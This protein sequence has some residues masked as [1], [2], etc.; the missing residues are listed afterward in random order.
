MVCNQYVPWCGAEAD[1]N[2]EDWRRNIAQWHTYTIPRVTTLPTQ[3][4][5]NKI[6]K[7]DP[8]PYHSMTDSHVPEVSPK[9]KKKKLLLKPMVEHFLLRLTKY[10]IYVII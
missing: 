2:H 9:L 4:T 10:Y 1:R 6:Y 7:N 3:K 8:L 5:Y